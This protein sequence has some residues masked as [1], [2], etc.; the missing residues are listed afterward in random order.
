MMSSE[1]NLTIK[2]TFIQA[3]KNHQ[4]NNFKVAKNLYNKI[5]QIE[6]NNIGALNNLGLVFQSLGE[7][8][9]AIS[10]YKKVIGID[11]NYVNANFNLGN[12]LNSLG[13]Y[14]EAKKYY[15]KVIR[16]DPI[17]KMVLIILE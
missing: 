1:N 2:E 13:N 4:N 12:V 15:K 9:E 5:I 10:C 3:L 8:Q 11:T 6:P 16:I 17:I 14:I 7:S